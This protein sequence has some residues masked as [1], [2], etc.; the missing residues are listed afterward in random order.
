ML[1]V[2]YSHVTFHFIF[3]AL[4]MEFLVPIVLNKWGLPVVCLVT[5]KATVM[6]S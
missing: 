1:S 2:A 5:G 6:L 4:T 3:I